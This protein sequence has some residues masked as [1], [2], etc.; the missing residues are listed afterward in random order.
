MSL[1]AF[2][3][4]ALDGGQV[5]SLRLRRLCFRGKWR[6]CPMDERQGCSQKQF[7]RCSENKNICLKRVSNFVFRVSIT[8]PNR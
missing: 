1:L 5:I 8:R 4:S 2:L 7:Q 3:T 6:R